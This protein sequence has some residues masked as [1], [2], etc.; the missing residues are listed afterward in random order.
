MRV[1]VITFRRSLMSMCVSDTSTNVSLVPY[2]CCVEPFSRVEFTLRL[3]RKPLYYISTDPMWRFYQYQYLSLK[4][5]YK[6]QYLS[7]KYQYQY[8]N[9][10]LR[11]GSSTSTS[12]SNR[13]SSTSTSIS[14]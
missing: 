4:Y 8:L 11:Y 5:T 14:T 12:T 10:I 13:V 6:Y 7:L 2:T 3:V 1:N 9:T